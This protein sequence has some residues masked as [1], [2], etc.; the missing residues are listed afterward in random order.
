MTT[1]ETSLEVR[2]INTLVNGCTSSTTVMD[3][4]VV[5]VSVNVPEMA[6]TLKA[7]TSLSKVDTKRV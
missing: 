3:A 2:L 4:G 6:D 7:A 1:S 5:W